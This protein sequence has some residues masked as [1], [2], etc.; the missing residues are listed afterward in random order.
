MNCD[1]AAQKFFQ[2]HDRL[3]N[4]TLALYSPDDWDNLLA[5]NA[6]WNALIH[7]LLEE[8]SENTYPL[9]EAPVT[10]TATLWLA[11]SGYYRQAMALLRDMIDLVLWTWKIRNDD[12]PRSHHNSAA[13]NQRLQWG[14]QNKEIP[15]I[16]HGPLVEHYRTF[17]HD[18]V[19]ETLHHKLLSPVDPKAV[20]DFRQ[21]LHGHVHADPARWNVVSYSNHLPIV[22][23]NSLQWKQWAENYIT[24]QFWCATWSL[25]M[26]PDLMT[27]ST[28]TPLETVYEM[29]NAC[30]DIWWLPALPT[31]T[32]YFFHEIL[33]SDS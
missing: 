4:Q 8:Y 9:I 28:N 1:G 14:I 11:S 24:V 32:M 5:Y 13:G 6:W 19:A 20:Q 33:G 18:N 17:I 29:P 15:H 31:E 26:F 2:A 25:L 21:D 12:N 23:F 22:Q 30:H 10:G 3:Q 7:Y 16:I 27:W